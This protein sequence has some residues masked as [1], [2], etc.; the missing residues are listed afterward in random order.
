LFS[1]SCCFEAFYVQIESVS[2]TQ[3]EKLK[4]LQKFL[5][6]VGKLSAKHALSFDDN[7]DEESRLLLLTKTNEL[8]TT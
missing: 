8:L 5:I 7:F 4:S 2:E 1:E 3:I 6:D